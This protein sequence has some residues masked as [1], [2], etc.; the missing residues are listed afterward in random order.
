N[1]TPF[2]VPVVANFT[3]IGSNP[4]LVGASG[5]YGMVLRR[6]TGGHY[7]NGVIAH[8][9]TGG[10]GYRDAQTKAR[11]TA[12][13]FSLQGLYVAETATLFQAGQQVYEAP[14]VIEHAPATTA[15]SLFT[16]L[17]SNPSTAS[18]FDWSLAA[19]VAP[20]T[21][22]VTSFSGDLQTRAGSFVTPTTFRGAADP[23]GAK[24][25]QGWTEYSDN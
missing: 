5:G 17:P 10:I 22:G 21:G 1:S 25:W 16:A 2:T 11:E 20:R 19:G 3:L 13:L 15:A 9:P 7:I 14:G 12:G 18:E 24:W 4:G 23:S 8:W 6:G